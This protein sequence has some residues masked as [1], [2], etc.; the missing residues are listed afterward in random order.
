MSKRRHHDEDEQDEDGGRVR[1]DKWLWAARFY[2]TR[3]LAKEA[4]EAGHVR[5]EGERSKVAKEVEVGAR[6]RVRQGWDERE[7]IVQ[8]LSVQR[9]GAAQAQLL[10][11]ETP[12]SLE[13]RERE[14][15]ERQAAHAAVSPVKP[16]KKARRLIH[17]FK[18]HHGWDG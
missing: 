14:R 18:R 12:E 6:L 15:L 8:A 9:G 13:R 10:Y 16:N 1:L 11:A 5:Y 7:V 2:R 17:H 4:I 3:T